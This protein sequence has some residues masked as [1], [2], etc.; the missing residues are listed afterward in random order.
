MLYD[1][2]PVLGCATLFGFF[3]LFFC[4]KWCQHVLG[5]SRMFFGCRGSFQDISFVLGC[6]GCFGPP[7]DALVVLGCL[8]LL[9]DVP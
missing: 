2:S 5:L 1:V 4:S 3:M 6:S 7:W 9:S 8:V